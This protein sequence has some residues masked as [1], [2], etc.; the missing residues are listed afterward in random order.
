MSVLILT[1]TLVIVI[2]IVVVLGL[3]LI[4]ALVLAIYMF[5]TLYRVAAHV[6][7]KEVHL[8]CYWGYI[9]VSNAC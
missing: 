4:L 7:C 3:A 1:L 5:F 6:T 2:V 9:G 8:I